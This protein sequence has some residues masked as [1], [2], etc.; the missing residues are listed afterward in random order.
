MSSK[1]IFVFSDKDEFSDEDLINTPEEMILEFE[2]PNI[3]F[4][5]VKQMFQ[6]TGYDHCF[7]KE[8]EG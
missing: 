3:D 6:R 4:D 2:Y 1:V 8:I 7:S 5:K